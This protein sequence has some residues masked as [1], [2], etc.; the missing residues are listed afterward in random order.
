VSY[1]GA[2]TSPEQMACARAWAPPGSRVNAHHFKRSVLPTGDT[3]KRFLSCS[4]PE[5]RRRAALLGLAALL[6]CLA[7]AQAYDFLKLSRCAQVRGGDRAP[8][9][10]HA[11]RS[12][13]AP[14]LLPRSGAESVASH[15]WFR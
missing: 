11:T 4:S 12:L 9:A 2:S 3:F 15:G 14:Q 5:M 8:A 10:C 6:G 1:E 7:S 13:S